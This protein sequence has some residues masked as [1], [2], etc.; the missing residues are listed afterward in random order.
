MYGGA[1]TGS[2]TR[3]VYPVGGSLFNRTGPALADAGWRKVMGMG[4][5]GGAAGGCIVVGTG[6]YD[7]IGITGRAAG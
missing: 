1:A 2:L 7:G 3:G 4:G 6:A 5:G